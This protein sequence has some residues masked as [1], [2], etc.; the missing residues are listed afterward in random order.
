LT[1]YGPLGEGARDRWTVFVHKRSD[2][3]THISFAI[4]FVP[5]DD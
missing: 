4:S 2:G 3:R 5:A 1:D